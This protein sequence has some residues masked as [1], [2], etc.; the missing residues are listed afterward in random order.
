M[1]HRTDPHRQCIGCRNVQPKKELLRLVLLPAGKTAFDQNQTKGGRGIYLCPEQKC[2]SLA[3]KNSRWRK[4]FFNKE[5]LLDLF[6][7]INKTLN[8]SIDYYLSLGIKMKC[9]KETNQDVDNLQPEDIVIVKKGISQEQKISMDT[10]SHDKGPV[11]FTIPGN[12]MKDATS[13]TIKHRFPMI[14]HLMRDLRIYER[15][16]SKGLVL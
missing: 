10:A 6:N 16:S 11:V 1:R 9:L 15:L 7:G 14:S 3:Y 2:F 13:V 4:Y 12:C 5:D 8:N